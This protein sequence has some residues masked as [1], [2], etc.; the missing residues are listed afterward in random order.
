[1]A[2]G[3]DSSLRLRLRL[4]CMNYLGKVRYVCMYRITA[5]LCR[6]TAHRACTCLCMISVSGF[7]CCRQRCRLSR[8]DAYIDALDG[9]D[10]IMQKCRKF[11]P[12]IFPSS[13]SNLSTF[14]LPF[15][16][17]LPHSH[18]TSQS[19][20]NASTHILPYPRASQCFFCLRMKTDRRIFNF[21]PLLSCLIYS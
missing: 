14:L 3:F 4:H 5:N 19:A 2:V 8:L 7:S 13:T 17:L 15:H 6:I 1:M 12:S 18:I 16:S 20:P 11:C 9:F 21:S 10:G